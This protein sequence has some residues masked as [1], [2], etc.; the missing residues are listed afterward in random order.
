[1]VTIRLAFSLPE[2]PWLFDELL[3]PEGMTNPRLSPDVSPGR[4]NRSGS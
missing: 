1:M 3:K 2:Q 4:V